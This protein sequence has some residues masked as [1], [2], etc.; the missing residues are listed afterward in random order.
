[1]FQLGNLSVHHKL[2]GLSLIG[3]GLV[4]AMGT[5]GYLTV[6]RLNQ[7][8]AAIT[9]DGSALRHQLQ[10]DMM[11]DALRGDVLSALMAGQQPGFAQQAEVE[12]DL[13]EHADT[14]R[15]AIEALQA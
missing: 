2:L 9:T 14:F 13:H 7:A 11:H 12:A 8:T 10:A 6:S 15:T 5:A 3:L 1:M 4:L